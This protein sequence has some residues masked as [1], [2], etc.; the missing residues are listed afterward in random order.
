M[1][2]ETGVTVGLTIKPLGVVLGRAERRQEAQTSV[3]GRIPSGEIH[4]CSSIQFPAGCEESRGIV[5]GAVGTAGHTT[6]HI[7]DLGQVTQLW[8]RTGE[9]N[10]LPWANPLIL[11]MPGLLG[12]MG[13]KL[14]GA[15]NKTRPT[16]TL[17]P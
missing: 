14:S 16:F 9:R 3:N 7:M 13:N 4:G 1:R 11:L 10:G 12:S 17:C 15:H 6:D 2:W 8:A 5:L